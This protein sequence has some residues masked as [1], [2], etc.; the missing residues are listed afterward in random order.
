MQSHLN[1]RSS[2]DPGLPSA[3]QHD[4]ERADVVVLHRAVWREDVLSPNHWEY[5]IQGEVVVKRIWRCEISC[6]R[7][8][9]ASV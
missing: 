4:I 3:E 1:W 8:V 7:K 6:D 5:F 9:V 2:V